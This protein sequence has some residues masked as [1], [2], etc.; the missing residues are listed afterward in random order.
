ME[1]LKQVAVVTDR[2]TFGGSYITYE[3]QRKTAYRPRI[4]TT[5][6]TCTS[7]SAYKQ[8]ATLASQK[9][10]GRYCARNAEHCATVTGRRGECTEILWTEYESE[11]ANGA[12]VVASKK[13]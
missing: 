8:N 2:K 1:T 6:L 4:S 9:K 7:R 11:R 3:R 13:K 12:V 10:L 5:Y